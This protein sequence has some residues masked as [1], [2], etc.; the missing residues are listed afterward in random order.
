MKNKFITLSGYGLFWSWNLILILLMIFLLFPEVVIPIVMGTVTGS[1]FLEQGIFSMLLFLVPLITVIFGLTKRFRCDPSLLLKLFYGIEL[2]L[3]FIIIARLTLFREFHP[4]TIHIFLMSFVAIFAFGWT[5]FSY[6]GHQNSKLLVVFRQIAITCSVILVMYIALFLFFF[7]FPVGKEFLVELFS[8]KWVVSI[9]KHPLVLL[10][11]VFVL[12]TFTLL[13]GL[14]IMLIALYGKAFFID[15]QKAIKIL[16]K[17]PIVLLVLLT[18]V[19]NGLIFYQANQQDQREAFALLEGVKFD[20]SMDNENQKKQLL[21]KYDEIRFGLVNAYLASY[22]YL[23]TEKSSNIIEELYKKSFGMDR[24]G[25]P[26]TLQTGF[27]FLAS[28]FLYQGNNW[29]YDSQKAEDLYIKF[30]DTPIEKAESKAINQALKSNWY[31]DGMQAGLINKDRQKVLI[32]QQSISIQEKTHSATITLNESYQNQTFEQQEIYYYFTLPEEAVLTGVWLSDDADDL[33]KYSYTV[34]PRGAAQKLYKQER[35]KRVDPAL[36]EQVGPMQ[37]RLRVFPIPAKRKQGKQFKIKTDALFMQLSYDIPLN[38]DKQWLLPKLLEKRNVYWDN[39]SS[40]TV[41][42]QIYQRPEDDGKDLWLPK[43]I[44]AQSAT[45]LVDTIR[46]ISL[47]ETEILQV[48]IEARKKQKSQEMISDQVLIND[49][50]IAILIDTSFSMTKIKHSLKSTL[51]QLKGL[52]EKPGLE[53]D[54]YAIGSSVKKINNIQ[55]WIVNEPVFFGHNTTAKQ[56]RQWQQFVND[57]KHYKAILLLTDQGNY[58]S[59]EKPGNE[60]TKT[61]NKETALWILH[62]G[63]ELAYA[64]ADKLLES[65]Y[66]SGGG[67]GYALNDV[68]ERIS[69]K[70]QRRLKQLSNISQNYIWSYEVLDKPDVFSEQQSALSAIIAHQWISADFNRRFNQRFNQR[71]NQGANQGANQGSNQP[72]SNKTQSNS[73]TEHLDGLHYLAKKNSVVSPFSSMIVLVNKRQEE[74]L[75]KL[76]KEKDRFKRDIDQGKKSIVKGNDLFSVSSVPEP[77]EWAL[78]IV[79]MFI[80]SAVSYKKRQEKKGMRA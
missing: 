24:K 55:D 13:L 58:E 64:Y 37:Y 8:F 31:R 56:L 18:V 71:S 80:L 11:V 69:W 22:R 53:I 63:N 52:L 60:M 20:K 57:S 38:T 59:K 54:F 67:V 7:V 27:N 41:N 32:T 17:A 72:A 46:Q 16:G 3:L 14:P 2:P 45:P 15:S 78:I 26:A 21:E 36:L 47:N 35:D 6:A 66:H 25:F 5:I 29:S 9:F 68:I 76:S 61:I 77:E 40:L 70:Q 23:S 12:Y 75:E 79:V 73:Q 42:G 62:L 74:A 49:Q 33:K 65:I 19:A 4:G 30:F 44:A 51:Q 50:S 34:A 1:I 39:S 43:T 48:H 28:P 10:G